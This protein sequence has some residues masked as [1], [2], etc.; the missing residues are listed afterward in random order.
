MTENESYQ[1]R[2]IK[3]GRRKKI[4]M[5]RLKHALYDLCAENQPLTVRQL[6]YRAV[7]IGLVDKTQNE[8]ANSIVRV[9]G[10]MR[11]QGELPFEWLVDNTRWMRKPNTYNGLQSM[12]QYTAR[13]YRRD[14]WQHL[15]T[16]VEIWCESDSIAGVLY[17]VT[18]EWDVPLMPTRG[19]SSKTFLKS[20]A[21]MMESE[22][23]PCYVYYFGDYDKSGL[24]ISDRIEKDL[25]R[26]LPE[27]FDF[28]FARVA[29]N[30]EQIAR[31]NLTTRPPKSTRARKNSVS[32]T[33]ELEAMTTANLQRIC[34]LCI[35]GHVDPEVL[36][37]VKT[38]E[39]AERETLWTIISGFNGAA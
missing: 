27:D 6:F 3:R 2:C 5:N 38:I 18:E 32:Q 33:V 36:H 4:E 20:S 31:Y 12:L 26:Y 7:S 8:Y 19:H 11:E 1:S 30:E 24:D 22:E 9:V 15:N 16:Y 23:K 35:E 29:I 10:I 28:H 13:T 17:P 34:R 25:R 21:E 37:R 39:N 14:L